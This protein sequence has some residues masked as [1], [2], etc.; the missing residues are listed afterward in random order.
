[1]KP[2][3]VGCSGTGQRASWL[4][5]AELANDGGP[6]ALP[7]VR[8][9]VGADEAVFGPFDCTDSNQCIDSK[10]T[11][12]PRLSYDPESQRYWLLY[13]AYLLRP[14]TGRPIPI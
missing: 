11:E 12:D 14:K 10:G 4:T 8:N 3:C 13:N 9:F 2:G 1:V 7:S 5:W 6:A